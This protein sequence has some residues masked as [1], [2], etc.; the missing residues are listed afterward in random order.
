[1][2]GMGMYQLLAHSMVAM[3]ISA[4]VRLAIFKPAKEMHRS[5]HRILYPGRHS[6]NLQFFRHHVKN[7]NTSIRTMDHRIIPLLQP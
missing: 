4:D 7:M 2:V 6:L 1:M 5:V 3:G